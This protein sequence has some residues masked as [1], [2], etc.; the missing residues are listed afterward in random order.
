M[1][2]IKVDD[3]FGSLLPFEIAIDDKIERKKSKN[4][5]FKANG[6]DCDD[7]VKNDEN[8]TEFVSLLANKFCKVMRIFDKISRSDVS[9][10]VKDNQQQISMVL[11]LSE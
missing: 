5:A 10:N 1:S 3:L 4:V 11:T 8:L 9:S 2:N 6:E 7:Q